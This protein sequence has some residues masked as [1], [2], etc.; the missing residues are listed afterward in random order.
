MILFTILMIAVFCNL[1]T[2]AVKLS[3]GLIKVIFGVICF[4]ITL[5][6][7]VIGGLLH[8]ATPILV[9]A[10]IVLLIVDR[11]ELFGK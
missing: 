8:I 10:L 7:F 3:W 9:V 6:L 5:V 4:P 11:K 1:V 2:L